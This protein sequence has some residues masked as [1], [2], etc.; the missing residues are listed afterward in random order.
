M[1]TIPDFAPPEEL[2]AAL[3]ERRRRRRLRPV[4]TD[5]TKAI[6]LQMAPDEPRV[7]DRTADREAL[8]RKAA[9]RLERWETLLED[10]LVKHFERQEEVVVARLRGTKVRRGTRHW[11]PTPPAVETK[12]LSVDQVLQPDRWRTEIEADTTRLVTRIFRGAATEA[13]EDLSADAP[14]VLD[15][16]DVQAYVTAAVQRLMGVTEARAAEV[17]KVIT[18]LDADGADLD[19]IV[20]AVKGTYDQ[21]LIWSATTARTET[22][23]TVNAASLYAAMQAG[24]ALKQ[25]LSSHDDRVRHTHTTFGGGDGQVALIGLPFVIGGFPLMYPGDPAG[26]PQQVINCRCSLLFPKGEEGDG[27]GTAPLVTYGARVGQRGEELD[28]QAAGR[29]MTALDSVLEPLLRASHTAVR[30]LGPAVAALT[31]AAETA[32]PDLL[33]RL[34]E[35]L[36]RHAAL[37][38]AGAIVLAANVR[39]D[40]AYTLDELEVPPEVKV[41]L[42]AALTAAAGGTVP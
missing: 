32:N 27:D 7:P 14:D 22:T 21:R 42:L 2:V 17:A 39:N 41:A 15:S 19:T 3:V 20:Q 24:L 13:A 12:A 10:L 23:G 6:R 18:D 28:R 16:P 36:Q 8:R 5:E 29:V 37:A 9:E 35:L 33:A 26:P 11:T 38:S 1:R 34:T 4:V 25:W 40:V 30:D 31:R